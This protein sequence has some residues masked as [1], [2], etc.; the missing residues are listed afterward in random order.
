MRLAVE[1]NIGG[2]KT[3]ALAALA[4]AFPSMPVFTEPVDEWADLMQLFYAAPAEWAL[5]FSLKVLLSFRRPGAATETCLVE[6]CPLATR[7]VFSQLL[8]NDGSLTHHEWELFKEYHD[9]LAWKPDAILY[10][11]TPVDVCLDR[12]RQRGRGAERG[13]EEDYLRRVDFQYA[14][15]LRFVD[16]PVLR[17]DGTLPPADLHAAM[18]DAV[19]KLIS[20]E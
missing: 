10:I 15:M 17:F 2:G 19:R 5:A 13:I 9:V 18:A 3:E 14:N 6:R 1:G 8:Y 11:D 7:H 16:V 20:E 12:I 4:S